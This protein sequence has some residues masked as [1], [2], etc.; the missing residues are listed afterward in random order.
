MKFYVVLYQ[1]LWLNSSK[2]SQE[3]YQYLWQAQK[4]CKSQLKWDEYPDN[5][6][7]YERNGHVY[8]NSITKQKYTIVE[9]TV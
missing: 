2:V 8:G 1:D 4:F 6:A 3:G 7:L 9:V 5:P